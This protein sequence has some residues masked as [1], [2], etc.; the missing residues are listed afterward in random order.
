MFVPQALKGVSSDL[1]VAVEL[2]E[3]I[4]HF[5]KRL[6]IYTKVSPTEAM[7]EIVV[8]ILVELLSTLALATKQIKQGRPS[9]SVFSDVLSYSMQCREI[10]KEALWGEWDRGGSPE[11]GPTNP[12]GGSDNGGTDA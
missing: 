1:E 10:R 5:L 4:E 9:E 8:K 7:T 12:G 2:L 11:A 6:D 3:S